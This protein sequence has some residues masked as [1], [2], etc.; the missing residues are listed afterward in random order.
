MQRLARPQSQ[1][2][3][4]NFVNAEGEASAA[5]GSG[6]VDEMVERVDKLLRR[7]E[8]LEEQVNTD[9]GRRPIASF[10]PERP[11]EEEVKE[12]NLTHTPPAP[13]CPY[14]VKAT[15][16]RD[17]HA[18]IRHEVPDVTVS[19]DRVPTN[20]SDFMYLYD[21]GVNPTLVAVDDEIGRVWS[22]ALKDKAILTG[23]GWIQR[24]LALDIDNA[25]ALM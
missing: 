10:V 22:Y 8:E 21:K 2:I 13:W 18:R 24:R 4:L 20:A 15:S 1:V 14:C 5:S 17:K 7:I 6:E 11:T 12:H 9:E 16:M 19:V 3:R 25:A 23:D